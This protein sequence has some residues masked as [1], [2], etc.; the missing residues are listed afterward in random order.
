VVDQVRRAESFDQEQPPR[1]LQNGSF[2]TFC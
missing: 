1:P 2:A